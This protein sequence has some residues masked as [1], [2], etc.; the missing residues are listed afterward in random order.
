MALLLA[1]PLWCF[2]IPLHKHLCCLS[3]ADSVEQPEFLMH[4][5]TGTCKRSGLNP[6]LMCAAAMYSSDQSTQLKHV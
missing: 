5:E 2:V 3:N 4:S 6:K 1:S